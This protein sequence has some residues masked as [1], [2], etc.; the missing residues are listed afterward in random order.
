[1]ANKSK[2]TDQSADIGKLSFETALDELEK[3]VHKLE[4]GKADLE[5]AIDAYTRGAAL[6]E[7]C[8]KKLKEAKARVDKISLGAGG[9]AEL[10]PAD[11][12]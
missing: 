6:K 5:D 2:S 1:M 4:D 3:I 9:A 8:E 12:E 11:L 10:E 7:H